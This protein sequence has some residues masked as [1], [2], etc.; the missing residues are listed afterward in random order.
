MCVI[1]DKILLMKK[2]IKQIIYKIEYINSK[3][4]GKMNDY[5][6]IIEIDNM[7]KSIQEE[8]LNRLIQIKEDYEFNIIEE[9]KKRELNKEEII[10]RQHNF[11]PLIFEM[12]KYMSESGK[13]EEC[14][15][16]AIEEEEI[17]Y[18]KE[19]K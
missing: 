4:L 18:K 17:E 5:N 19:K 8:E 2:E 12:L 1:D 11:L 9:E 7:S 15:N 6:P 13:L 14:Y 16:K 10:R 3:L